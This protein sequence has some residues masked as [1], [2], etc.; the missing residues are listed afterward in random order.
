[1]APPPLSWLLRLAALCHLTTLLAGQH[2]GV[3]KCSVTCSKMTSEI[4]VAL[5]V[6]YERNQESC[7]KRAIM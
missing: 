2:H 5:L 1:M 7:G 6:H 3:K 4:P